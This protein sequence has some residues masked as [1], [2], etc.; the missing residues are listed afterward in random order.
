MLSSL[1]VLRTADLALAFG[2]CK[3]MKLLRIAVSNGRHG[4]VYC[5]PMLNRPA[6][7]YHLSGKKKKH[8][9]QRLMYRSPH[10]LVVVQ[11]GRNFRKDLARMKGCTRINKAFI[12]LHCN[13]RMSLRIMNLQI[14]SIWTIEPHSISVLHERN[15]DVDSGVLFFS[16]LFSGGAKTDHIGKGLNDQAATKKE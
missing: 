8:L 14:T 16:L 11:T 5:T 1:C 13:P 6:E 3:T 4:V 12:P 15:V 9:F 10:T 2:N 7:K